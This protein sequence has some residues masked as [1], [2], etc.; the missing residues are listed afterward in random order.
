MKQDNP[1]IVLHKKRIT[2]IVTSCLLL[3]AI[4]TAGFYWVRET[5]RYSLFWFKRAILQRDADS[6]LKYIDLD[7]ILDNMVNQMSD[8][9]GGQAVASGKSGRTLGGIS[10]DVVSQN[11]PSIKSQLREQ[12]RS[13]ILSYND[14]AVLEKLSKASVLGLR[15]TTKDNLATVRVMGRDKIAFTMKKSSEGRWKIVSLNLQELM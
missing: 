11:L 3:V 10:K 14:Q 8:G 9:A 12:L 4:C 6:A 7:S 13:A 1:H 5:P 2:L 15:I